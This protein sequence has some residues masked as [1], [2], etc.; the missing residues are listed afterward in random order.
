[1]ENGNLEQKGK[2]TQPMSIERG[3]SMVELA[4]TLV[5]ILILLAG[6][7]D[8]GRAFFAYIAMRDAA[9]E[10]ALYGS[11][12]PSDS[13]GID[14]RAKSVL[15]SR[16]DISN[17]T[18]TPVISGSSCGNGSNS[19]TVT[20]HYDNF[21]ITMTFLGTIVGSQGFDITASVIDTIL[22]PACP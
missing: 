4:I 20:V 5:A 13:S 8:L 11:T 14:S 6:I 2:N 19:I 9:Q 18:I 17:I 1:M 12:A 22:S 3:Q 10:G 16:V 15:A 7:V 21:A